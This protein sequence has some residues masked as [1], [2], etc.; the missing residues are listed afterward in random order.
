M[1]NEKILKNSFKAVKKEMESMK[2]EVAFLIKRIATLENNLVN[3]A[4]NAPI[5]RKN[6]TTFSQE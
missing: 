2:D 4:I 1:V 5:K 6:K 3:Q